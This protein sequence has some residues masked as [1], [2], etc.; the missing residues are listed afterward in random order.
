MCIS[1]PK[2]KDLIQSRQKSRQFGTTVRVLVMELWG[3]ATG[4]LGGRMIEL[5]QPRRFMS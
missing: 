1:G 2:I 5:A 4:V 3:L